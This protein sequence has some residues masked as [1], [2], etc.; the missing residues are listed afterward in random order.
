M[1]WQAGSAIIDGRELTD[2][3]A[4]AALNAVASSDY[5]AAAMHREPKVCLAY[6]DYA[7]GSQPYQPFAQGRC[8]LTFD[9]WIHNRTDLLLS[10]R[11][12]LQGADTDAAIALACFRRWGSAGFVHLVGDWSL[13]IWNAAERAIVLASD[14]A[15]VRPLYYFTD[16]NRILWSSRLGP[17][18]QWARAEDLDDEYV[19]GLL[20]S[21]GCPNHTPYRGI[22]SPPPGCAVTF[23]ANGTR[24]ERFWH[25]PVSDQIRYRR[26]SEYEEHL[27]TLL[28]EAVEARLER[29]A[30][31]LAELS[32]G[33]D[34]SSIVCMA[35]DSMRTGRISPSKIVTLSVEHPGSIDQ[36]FYTAVEKACGFESVHVSTN[37]HPFLTETETGRA[38][39]AFWEHL[40]RN[41]ADIAR[42]FG[43]RT[44]FTGQL[45]DLVMGNVWDDSD[46]VAG[47]IARGKFFPALREALAWAKVQR[48]PIWWILGRAIPAS[49][50]S[51][52]APGRIFGLGD[53][54]YSPKMTA[55]SIAPDFRKNQNLTDPERF[56]SSTWR[57][58][59]PERRKHFRGLSQALELRKLQPSEPLQHLMFT[60]PFAHRPLVSFM[61]SI[62]ADIVC[63][64]GE[65]RRLMRRALQELWPQALRKRKSKDAFGGV[66]LESLS[67]LAKV[68][69]I[70]KGSCQ[71]VER[72]FV[73]GTSLKHRLEQMSNSLDCNEPQLRQILLLEF[74]LR[75]RELR[76][77][78]RSWPLSA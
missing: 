26:E 53:G 70:E 6:A 75:N 45:G 16:R 47:L 62:P 31:A 64:P 55:D 4:S 71:V 25:L 1:A 11:E 54:P 18:V 41:T 10:L 49:L 52:L 7:A 39:P 3:E 15:G 14:F 42:G 35:S 66:Y 72:G 40:H 17:L 37:S 8:T 43:A 44:Y 59:A 50:P 67:R 33:L 76:A 63:R 29:G 23:D 20:T 56:F 12:E 36:P 27:R 73:D 68:L 61:S 30:P 58:A 32:G 21:G 34:S 2:V 9:G 57:Q 69:L 74:W 28:R 77:G 13:V 5:T 38:A 65:P 60:H 24:T 51:T 22:L 19:A 46:Q 48:V 78:D